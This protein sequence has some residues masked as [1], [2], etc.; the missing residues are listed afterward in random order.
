[1][2]ISRQRLKATQSIRDAK[3]TQPRL[4]KM[5]DL[6]QKETGGLLSIYA[7]NLSKYY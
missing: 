1:M 4:C 7:L 3:L 5:K 6:L 2:A